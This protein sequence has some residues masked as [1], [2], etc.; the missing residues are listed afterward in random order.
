[1]CRSDLPIP[2]HRLMVLSEPDGVH[3]VADPWTLAKAMGLPEQDYGQTWFVYCCRAE[4]Q[5]A[6]D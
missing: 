4:Y 1:M 2:W 3:D 5:N 6:M